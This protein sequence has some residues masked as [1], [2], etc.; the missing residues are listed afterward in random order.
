MMISRGVPVPG[1]FS[2][3]EMKRPSIHFETNSSFFLVSTALT[4][5]K[6]L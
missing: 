1:T 5:A 3:T 4:F 2:G 6:S